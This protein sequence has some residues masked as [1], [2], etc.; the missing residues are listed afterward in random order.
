MT[1]CASI[2]KAEATVTQLTTNDAAAERVLLQLSMKAIRHSELCY[3]LALG[4]Y[5]SFCHCVSDALLL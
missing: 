3:I 4:K 5:K 2:S 1:A